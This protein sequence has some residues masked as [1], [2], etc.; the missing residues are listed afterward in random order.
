[1][2]R[3]KVCEAKVPETLWFHGS[4][5]D[6]ADKLKINPPSPENIFFVAKN[7]MY[8]KYYADQNQHKS[9]ESTSIYVCSLKDNRHGLKLFNISDDSGRKTKKEF[10]EFCV[11]ESLRFAGMHL[12]NAQDM[13]SNIIAFIS[14][15]CK[16]IIE[17]GYDKEELKKI[18]VFKDVKSW[19]IE[20]FIK[21]LPNFLDKVGLTEKDIL[22]K[23]NAENGAV[24][25]KAY[26][27]FWK[28]IGLNAFDT[29]ESK[30]TGISDCLGI[31][32]VSALDSIYAMY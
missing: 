3:E 17:S 8:A 28:K 32:D 9:K 20:T 29:V 1:M 31:F 22:T 6:D 4:R 27:E 18:Y 19:V 26:C 10:G 14:D 5:F 12:R 7:L 25:R 2:K 11:L 13:F 21:E 15:Y 30:P 16:P 23:N 24:V